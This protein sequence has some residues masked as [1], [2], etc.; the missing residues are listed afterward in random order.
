MVENHTNK[1]PAF[2]H[3]PYLTPFLYIVN[4]FWGFFYKGYFNG[5]VIQKIKVWVVNSHRNLIEYFSFAQVYCLKNFG[6]NLCP[7][8]QVGPGKHLFCKRLENS[9]RRSFAAEK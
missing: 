1:L 2:L 3:E 7:E 9:F 5:M 6:I 8:Q 4:H